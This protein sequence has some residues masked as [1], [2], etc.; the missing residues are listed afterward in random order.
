MFRYFFIFGKTPELS[1]YELESV[2]NRKKPETYHLISNGRLA[3][4]KTEKTLNLDRLIRILGG[5][6]KIAIYLNEVKNKELQE[7]VFELLSNEARNVNK[8]V[9]ALSRISSQNKR[10]YLDLT[11]QL[12][13]KLQESGISSRYLFSKNSKELTSAQVD[14]AKVTEFYLIDEKD[15]I[16]IAKTAAIQD[17]KS[18]SLRDYKRPYID[19]RGGMLPPKIARIMIN[20]AFPSGA[21]SQSWLLDPFC[22]AGTIALEAMD[23]GINSI[24]SDLSF[25]KVEGTRSNLDWFTRFSPKNINWKVIHQDATQISKSISTKVDAVVTEPY[26]GPPNLETR[27]LEKI[28]KGLN[29]LYLGALKNWHNL[30]KKKGRVVIVLPRFKKVRTH[31]S[32]TLVIDRRENLGYTLVA[33][34]FIYARPKAEI[35]RLIFI[36][37]KS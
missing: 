12:K 16:I 11:R 4:L 25:N 26:L 7:A 24:N 10:N 27:N 9:F 13:T 21:T 19:P 2:L 22:G 37:E 36:L 14:L 8:L 1:F 28:I 20:L 30:L 3:V 15:K 35:E 23:L 31:N 17:Y 34:P 18:F 33:G 32:A 6:V 5:T 29:K